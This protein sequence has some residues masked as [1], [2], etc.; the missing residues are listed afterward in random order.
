MEG[1]VF[2]PALLSKLPDA[3]ILGQPRCSP[4]TRILD[5]EDIFGNPYAQN[6]FRLCTGN[7]AREE[8]GEVGTYHSLRAIPFSEA[9]L[10]RRLQRR[11]VL[12]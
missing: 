10:R 12:T 7:Q 6:S 3:G 1:L 2:L 8:G 5:V 9:L 11:N 4:K